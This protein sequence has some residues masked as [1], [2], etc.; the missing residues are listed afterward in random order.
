VERLAYGGPGVARADGFAIFVEGAAPDERV[1]ARIRRTYRR[2]AEADLVSIEAASPSRVQPRCPHVEEGCGGCGWQHVAYPAQLATKAEVVRDSLA[3]LAG[4]RELPMRAIE[5]APAELHYRN[6][7]EFAFHPNGTLGLHP[8][9]AW[10]D[11]LRLRECYLGPPLAIRLVEAARGFVEERGLSLFH[12]RTREGLLRELIVRASRSTGEILVGIV[13]ASGPF[14]EARAMAERLAAVDPA[15][16]GVLRSIRGTADAGAPLGET[17]VLLG[18]DHV[19]ET[20]AGLRFRIHLDTF[21]QTN[22]AQAERLVELVLEL[23]G[24]VAGAEV[25]DVYCGVGLFSLALA[26]RG[27]RVTGVEM[28]ESAVSGVIGPPHATR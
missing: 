18:R 10:Y 1:R 28:V 8:R 3:R 9:G 26:A 14:P 4:L 23:A 12:P 15:V 6:K 19:S 5:A 22:S 7:M 21:Y 20:T 13:T 16:V 24:D 25:V 27:A 11:I 2:H 17:T